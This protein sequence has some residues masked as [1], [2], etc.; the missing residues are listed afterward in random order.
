MRKRLSCLVI[1]TILF[2]QTVPAQIVPPKPAPTATPVIAAPPTTGPVTPPAAT[3]EKR[4]VIF[5]PGILGSRL[6]NSETGEGVW[7]NIKRS[8]TDDLRLPMSSPNIAANRDKIVA[9]E[10]LDKIKILKYFP[11]ISVY[12]GVADF[13]EANGYKAGD[14]N[15]PTANGAK[16]D[17]DTYYL[18]AYDWRRDNV[19]SAAKLIQQIDTLRRKLGKPDLKFDLIAHSMGGLVARYAAMY[20]HADLTDNPRPNWEGSK[21]FHDVCLFGVP[22]DGAMEAF[23]TMINGYSFDILGGRR[24]LGVLDK[25][26]ALSSPALFELLPHGDNLNFYDEELQPMHVD[27]YDPEIWKTY[28]WSAAFDEQYRASLNKTALQ[29]IDKYFA[30]VLNRAKKFHIALAVKS[31]PPPGLFFFTYGSD[32]KPTLNGA[33]IYKEKDSKDWETLTHGN[34]FRNSKGEKVPDDQVKKALYSDGDGTVAKNSLYIDSFYLAGIGSKL[35]GN[36]AAP[37]FA[38]EA[39]ASLLS[40]KGLQDSL[41]EELLRN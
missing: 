10:V 31:P 13:F 7:V 12:Q 14:W 22:N 19:E 27:I 20:G 23:D 29:Q 24:H 30:A 1:L 11:K 5:I 3:K 37:F 15:N 9:S 32:C 4:P 6:K 39:H 33:V 28:K 25:E 40:N 34:S 26:V 35:I 36:A 8:K 2:L 21:Y 41:L 18:F 16:G 38:C 17:R